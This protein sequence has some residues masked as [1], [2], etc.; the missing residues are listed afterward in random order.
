LVQIGLERVRQPIDQP[1]ARAN[2]HAAPGAAFE[3]G[4]RAFHGAVDI[5]SGRIRNPRDHVAGCGI[6]DVQHLAGAGLD[7]A[8]VDEIAVDFDGW[9]GGNIQTP[10]PSIM[11]P[12]DDD[13]ISLF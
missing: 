6:A 7:L 13:L 8:A 10:L 11:I 1:C 5:F 9:F 2:I 4:A 3:G 12:S